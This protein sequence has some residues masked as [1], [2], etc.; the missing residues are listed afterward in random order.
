VRLEPRAFDLLVYVWG[1]DVEAD[2]AGAGPRGRST[3]IDVR[4]IAAGVWGDRRTPYDTMKYHVFQVN[5]A[6]ADLGAPITLGK[7]RGRNTIT[8]SVG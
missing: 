8:L 6:M 7:T 2:P 3:H 1:R 4:D 5:S